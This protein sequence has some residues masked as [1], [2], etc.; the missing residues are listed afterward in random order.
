MAS[1]RSDQVRCA[2]FVA[3]AALLLA[4]GPVA[5]AQGKA[6]DPLAAGGFETVPRT[7]VDTAPLLAFADDDDEWAEDSSA[8]DD[9]G[10]D[11]ADDSAAS[12]DVGEGGASAGQEDGEVAETGQPAS[13][14]EGEGD[15]D[16][17][18]PEQTSTPLVQEAAPAEPLVEESKAEA[19]V[20]PRLRRDYSGSR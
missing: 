20:D 1:V 3:V 19:T 12:D 11:P 2:G 17:V 6:A 15:G 7:Y 16:G 8:D 13:E 10:G 9:E 18:S 14:G 4:L 5:G